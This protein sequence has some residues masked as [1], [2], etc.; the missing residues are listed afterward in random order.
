MDRLIKRLGFITGFAL[1]VAVSGCSD[2]ILEEITSLETSRL[3][4]PVDIEV[5]VVNQ[6]GVRLEWAAVKNAQHYDIEFFD[7][8]TEDFSGTPERTVE[9]VTYDEVPYTVLG[10]MGETEYS[11]RIKAVGGGIGDSKWISATFQ[12]DAEQI[13][14][15]VDPDELEATEVILRW[16][17]GETATE[18]VLSPGD[19]TH[20][21]TAAEIEAG[22]ATVTG[23]APETE[24]TAR[25][26]NDGRTRGTITFTTLLDLGGAIPVYPEDDLTELLQ[27]ANEG[28]VFALLPGQY[29]TQD[30]TISNTIGIKGARPADKPVLVGTVFRVTDGAGLELSDLVLDGTGAND[31]NQTIIY[32][33]GT[34]GDLKIENCEITNY[35]KGVLYV[36]NATLIESVSIRGTIYSEIEC[37]GGDFI[38][39]RNGLAK[40]FE[41][42]D[43]TAYNSALARDFFRMDGGGSSNFPDVNSTITITNN[44][45]YNVSNGD[46]RRMLYIR[47]ASHEI[48]FTRNILAN[49]EGY[50]SNQNATNIVTMN[51]N[52]Y[53]NAP[54][55]T[56]STQSNAQNDTGTYTTFDPGFANPSAGD[57][58]VGDEEL[59]FRGIGAR[60]WIR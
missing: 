49:T 17:A 25:L 27:A 39:F 7:N 54:N 30:I 4:S 13:F 34:F 47:L 14:Q 44:T 35:V 20:T 2:N 11:V 46:S 5:R 58:T 55:F 52:N 40:T 29:H 32:A 22:A 16:I 60:R 24:Y 3:F 18:I 42:V 45:F 21:V 12:T 53:F 48:S 37:N 9:G 59:R 8:G 50:Y 6:T 19:V 41:F 28:D 51:N 10:L 23:L 56:G 31:G 36:N 15:P 1:M 26:L 57:F 43:N 33:A 38:D